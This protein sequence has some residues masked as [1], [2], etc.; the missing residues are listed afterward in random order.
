MKIAILSDTHSRIGT[1][2]A[3]LALIAAHG[4]ELILHC[5]DIED[6]DTVR[7]F[8]AGTPTSSSATATTTATASRRADRRASARRCTSRSATWSWT[9]RS[10]PSSHGDDGRLLHDLEHAR[11]TSTTSSTATRTSRDERHRADARHQPGALHRARPKTFV[12]LD[13]ATGE[14]ESIVVE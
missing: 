14:A 12:I 6:A 9:A 4:V 2:E 13:V 11:R 8:P 1:V 10:S 7:L 5:G 3:A